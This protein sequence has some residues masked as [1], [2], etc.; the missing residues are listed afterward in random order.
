[1]LNID[2]NNKELFGNDAGEDE[3]IEI[4][5]SYY[6]EREDLRDFGDKNVRLNVVSARKGMGKSSLLSRLDYQLR[7]DPDYDDPIV[8]RV[9][10]NTLLGLGDFQ[11]KDQ[12]YLENYWKQIICK[13]IVIEIGTSMG[14]ALSSDAMSMVEI[15][16]LEGMKNKN[17]VGG[18]ISRIKVK[19]PAVSVETSSSIPNNMENLLQTYQERKENSTAWLLVDDIDAKYVDSGEYQERISSFFSAIRSL[20]FGMKNLNIRATVRTDVWANLRRFEDLD[21]WDQ[22][23]VEIN[24]TK[25]ELRDM[26]ANRVLGNPP[27]SKHS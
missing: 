22:Y 23:I 25:R 1:M 26:L 18:L 12:A 8:V 3:K 15:A 24:W 4:L 17:F 7:N 27:I 21:K 10:G 19:I 16:E 5:N 9:T 11:N 13:K 6:I 2:L 20:A 14:I